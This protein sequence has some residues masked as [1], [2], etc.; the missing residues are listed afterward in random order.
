MVR[1]TRFEITEETRRETLILSIAGELDLGTVPELAQ[2]IEDKLGA[3]HSTLDIDL[4]EVTF[5]DSSGLRLLIEINQRSAKERWD[6]TL[7][8]PQDESAMT[9]FQLTGAD[10]ALPFEEPSR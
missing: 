7:K 5:I 6:L 2:R 4:G 8:Y 1:P 3:N 10:K 9:V